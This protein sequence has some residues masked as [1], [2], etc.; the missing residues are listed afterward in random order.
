M[1]WVTSIKKIVSISDCLTQKD[2][3]IYKLLIQFW[4]KISRDP[5]SLARF[6]LFLLFFM[7]LPWKIFSN[8]FF[9]FHWRLWVDNSISSSSTTKILPNVEFQPFSF[10]LQ[11]KPMEI[12]QFLNYTMEYKQFFQLSTKYNKTLLIFCVLVRSS[13]HI[14]SGQRLDQ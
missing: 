10:F 12:L 7:I 8:E 3:P 4:S 5:E 14:K 1:Q 11:N 13:S 6:Q 9:N 2:V